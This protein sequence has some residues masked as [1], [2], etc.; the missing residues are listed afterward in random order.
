MEGNSIYI[1]SLDNPCLEL[2]ESEETQSLYKVLIRETLEDPN[3]YIRT[4]FD[5]GFITNSWAKL[6][7]KTGYLFRWMTK[8]VKLTQGVELSEKD[9]ATRFW[10]LTAMPATWEALKEGKL[11]KLTTWSHEGMVVVSGRAEMGLEKYYGVTHLPV[12]MASTRIAYLVMLDAHNQDHSNRDTTLSTALQTCWIAGGGRNLAGLIKDTCV[13]CRFLDRK[14]AGQKMAPLPK[15]LTIPCPPFSH[16]GLDLAGPVKLKVVGGSRATRN[17]TGEFKCWIV[18]IICLNTKAVKL[19]AACGY[20]TSDFL[21]TWEEHVS[22]CGHPRLVHSDRGSQLTSAAR[23]V[24]GEDKPNYDW[25]T[26]TVRNVCNAC[27]A[28]QVLINMLL[29]SAIRYTA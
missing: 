2:G 16:I 1:H 27:A 21:L 23:E 14:L 19:Y 5:N 29:Q 20:A 7:R 26:I 25:D 3:S 6:L 4:H 15:E 13:R 24:E 28:Q 9:L 10:I 11:K 18:V 17:K 8:A 22:D 12:I